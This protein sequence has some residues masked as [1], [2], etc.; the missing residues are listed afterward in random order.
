MQEVLQYITVC[1][2]G[3]LLFH[4][5]VVMIVEEIKT[6]LLTEKWVPGMLAWYKVTVVD[7]K[8]PAKHEFQNLLHMVNLNYLN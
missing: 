6:G 7:K 3:I 8:Y 2:I 1:M 4:H 5:V